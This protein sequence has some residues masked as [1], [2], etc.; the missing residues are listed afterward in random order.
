MSRVLENGR[1]G[2]RREK[3]KLPDKEDRDKRGGKRWIAEEKEEV[4]WQV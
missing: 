4:E 1:K 2:E 3:V